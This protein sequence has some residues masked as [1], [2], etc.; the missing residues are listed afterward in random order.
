MHSLEQSHISQPVPVI[1]R[2]SG[3][4]KLN[5]HT[6]S[7]NRCASDPTPNKRS[8]SQ[9]VVHNKK[10]QRDDAAQVAVVIKSTRPSPAQQTLAVNLS[11]DTDP[12]DLAS[13]MQI[14]REASMA[15][16]SDDDIDTIEDSGHRTGT[17]SVSPTE[18]RAAMQSPNVKTPSRGI[19][20]AQTYHHSS[21]MSAS[22]QHEANSRKRRSI[23]MNAEGPSKRIRRACSQ[24]DRRTEEIFD[25]IAV[26]QS[27]TS[28][29]SGSLQHT[30]HISQSEPPTSHVGQLGHDLT[31]QGP[32]NTRKKR[33]MNFRDEVE[34]TEHPSM[35]V[36]DLTQV[37]ST[38]SIEDS[39][40]VGN[41]GIDLVVAETPSKSIATRVKRRRLA[42]RRGQGL[43]SE[44]EHSENV[45]TTFMEGNDDT[46][47]V[48][49]TYIPIPP[50]VSDESPREPI[51]LISSRVRGKA[52]SLIA[53]ESSSSEEHH[54]NE[55]PTGLEQPFYQ[56]ENSREGVQTTS[57]IIQSIAQTP[58]R[59]SQVSVTRAS[60]TSHER[61]PERA[62]KDMNGEGNQTS[63]VGV[64]QAAP[65]PTGAET[66][67][68][69]TSASE[70]Q[71]S[72]SRPAV[73][74]IIGGL[75]RIL[76]DL[77]RAVLGPQEVRQIDDLLFDAKRE[78]F[79]AERRRDG[80]GEL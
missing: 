29:G 51:E 34:I 40:S 7:L 58:V 4:L 33:G 1:P 15:A 60:G 3:S 24:Q 23:S 41:V 32:D 65:T 19:K 43:P 61:P 44:A 21:P 62:E 80:G 73:S 25:C 14:S 59:D 48:E 77:R 57:Y 71:P 31:L 53:V 46:S 47:M 12:A 52:P 9:V 13:A 78:T 30:R 28:K 2:P 5:K 8:P 10:V 74:G 64:S 27:P 18:R 75:K 69:S 70:T 39:S 72:P 16:N 22:I 67:V 54:P 26:Q 68:V 76:S 35:Q 11:L 45:M 56:S 38:D 66:G 20:R 50:D 49:E 37:E 55:S 42:G 63:P 6:P 36:F 17:R 79:A